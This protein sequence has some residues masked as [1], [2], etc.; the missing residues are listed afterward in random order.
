MLSADSLKQ[1]DVASTDGSA[2]EN[3]DLPSPITEGGVTRMGGDFFGLRALLRVAP[4][5]QRHVADSGGLLRQ[6]YA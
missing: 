6:T 1:A 5:L 4:G 3:L 2:H